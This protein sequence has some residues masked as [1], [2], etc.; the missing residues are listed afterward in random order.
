MNS[1]YETHCTQ[2]IE[3]MNHLNGFME[4]LNQNLQTGIPYIP[5]GTEELYIIRTLNPN[6][7]YNL[8]AQIE[9]LSHEET[10]VVPV[11]SE[12]V[13][14]LANKGLA[15]CALKID[16]ETGE[17]SFAS[18]LGAEDLTEEMLAARKTNPYASIGEV[19]S[20]M[21]VSDHRKKGLYSL[22]RKIQTFKIISA[23]G[24][25]PIAFTDDIPE[26]YNGD[27][28]II[29]GA[30]G[31]L[32]DFGFD[33]HL[34]EFLPKDIKERLVIDC[35]ASRCTNRGDNHPPCKCSVWT[36][37]PEV[38]ENWKQELQFLLLNQAK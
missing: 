11:T 8:V 18:F 9:A 38:L 22:M 6:N 20:A 26:S 35:P 13:Y 30:I 36:P 29:S 3:H 14:S 12:T 28:A 15:L 1:K 16:P 7:D 21:T 2:L 25:I 32:K 17:E 24:L 4:A 10:A 31:R 33:P 27:P 19:R 23:Y 5:E 37:T 34:V